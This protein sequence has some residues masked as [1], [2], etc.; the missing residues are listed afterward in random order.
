MNILTKLN[1][2]LKSPRQAL[3]GQ[4][5]IVTM[6]FFDVEVSSV[7]RLSPSFIRIG[8]KGEMVANM[9]MHAP[10]QW[11]KLY[12]PNA[13]GS[14][15][16][17]QDQ[18]HYN[19]LSK[20]T[21]PAVRTYT[22]RA[23]RPDANEFDVDFVLH[24]DE[25][26][27]SR[28]AMNAQIG[29]RMQIRAHC[30]SANDKPAGCR[31][32]PLDSSKKFVLFA[33]ETGLPAVVGILEQLAEL[34]KPPE[35]SVFVEI[36]SQDDRFTIPKWSGLNLKYLIKDQGQKPGDLLYEEA[37]NLQFP[38]PAS[39]VY[40][41]LASETSAVRRIRLYLAD[42]HKLDKDAISFAGYWKYGE[43]QA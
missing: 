29:N 1:T 11:I 17:V 40:V 5:K 9:R 24:G 28:W 41:W 32:V 10:D 23:L 38:M 37:V 22:I 15:V 20:D 34:A 43:K 27:A 36:P 3:F 33:D 4:K 6:R 30:L 12:I 26:P 14:V 13:D 8:F 35:V 16:K 39:D 18:A 2:V 25:G 21:R 7:K 42:T 19:G 31:W